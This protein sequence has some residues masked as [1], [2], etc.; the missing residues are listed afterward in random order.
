MLI[1]S[2]HRVIAFLM[3]IIRM[4]CYRNHPRV[5]MLFENRKHRF[6]FR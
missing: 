1:L 4:G 5:S 3:E 2:C 6:E